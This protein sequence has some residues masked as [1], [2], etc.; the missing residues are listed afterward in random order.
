MG[1]FQVMPYHFSSTDNPYNPDTNALR[2]LAYL[3][4]SMETAGGD[5]RLALAG[6]NGGI[7][8]IQRSEISWHSETA[9]YV[10]YGYPIYQDAERGAESSSMLEE[11][12][13]RYGIN[14]C[15]QASQRLGLH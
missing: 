7:G 10:H 13:S 4:R 9:R 11:W 2:G 14:L 8:I 5:S 6:Y 3:K 12:Y 15:K 1:L